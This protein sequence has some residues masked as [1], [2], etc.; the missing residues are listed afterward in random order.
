MKTPVKP[1]KPVKPYPPLKSKTHNKNVIEIQDLFFKKAKYNEDYDDCF[2]ISLKKI[3]S[4]FPEGTKLEDIYL[5]L[6]SSSYDDYQSYVFKSIDAYYTT[7]YLYEEE[8]KNYQK[9]LSNYNKA[10]LKYNEQLLE[11]KKDY[12]AYK[13]FKD[14]ERLKKKKEKLEAELKALEL[15]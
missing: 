12:Q 9:K 5:S 10:I 11:Y 14:A 2:D 6:N 8:Y 15:K 1:V 4:K 13:L 7:P 3:V